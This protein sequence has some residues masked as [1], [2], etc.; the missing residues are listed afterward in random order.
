[1][2]GDASAE[3]HDHSSAGAIGL[4]GDASAKARDHSTAGAIRMDGGSAWA[5]A[6]NG[7]AAAAIALN[8]GS[9]A[10]AEAGDHNVASA[11]ATSGATSSAEGRCPKP[12]ESVEGPSAPVSDLAVSLPG[13]AAATVG[14]PFT[15]KLTAQNTGPAS[16][17]EVRLTVTLPASAP[18]FVFAFG[19]ATQGRCYWS[20]EPVTK[21]VCVIGS[22][23]P[24]QI[25]NASIVLVPAA[26][27]TLT[28]SSLISGFVADGNPANDTASQTAT[29]TAL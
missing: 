25:V 12:E 19:A 8:P 2:D 23:A 26:T 16:V 6:Q 15:F 10:N 7:S 27:G 1:L 22:L 9:R 29:V 13:T 28:S 4:N 3:A 21:V 5:C 18:R 17:D 20:F 14:V 11:I 24:G